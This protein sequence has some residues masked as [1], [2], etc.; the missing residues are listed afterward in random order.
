[1]EGGV[2]IILLLAIVVVVGFVVAMYL[3]GGALLSGS[4][5]NQ[6]PPREKADPVE[7]SDVYA[8][9]DELR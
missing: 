6:T 3:T 8:Q 4:R 9:H 1:M 7:R 2:G 5:K